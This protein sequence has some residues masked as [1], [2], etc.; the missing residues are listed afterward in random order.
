MELRKIP[1]GVKFPINEGV[2]YI[3]DAIDAV[4]KSKVDAAIALARSLSAEQIALLADAMAK[5]TQEQLDTAVIKGDSSVEAAQ[6]RFP[7]EGDSYPTLK[8]RLD[9]EYSEVTTQLNRVKNDLKLSYLYEKL[10]GTLIPY[11]PPSEF[12]LDIPFNIYISVSGKVFI[13]DYDVA[14]N[15]NKV[16]KIYYVDVKSGDNTNP[17]T[18]AQPFKDIGRALRYGDADEIIVKEGIYGWTSGYNGYTQ[19]KSYNL[20]GQGDVYVG[21]HRDNLIWTPH[22]TY[23]GV[24]QTNATSVFE[25][26]D[27]KNYELPEFLTL[28]NDIHGVS[29]TPNSYYIDSSN[30][31]Y[32]RTIDSRKPDDFILCNLVNNAAN[33]TN[34]DNVYFENIKFTNTVDITTTSN[35]NAMFHAKGCDFFYGSN[36]NG[37]YLKGVDFIVQNCRAK[38][39][40]RDGFNYHVSNGILSNGIE[41]DCE[42]KYNGRDGGNSNNGSTMHDGGHI[43]RIRGEYDHNHGPNVIDVNVGTKSLN[44]GVHAHSSTATSPISNADFRTRD[45]DMWLVNCVSHDSDYS[46]S[47]EGNANMYKD[48]S[49]LI[50]EEIVI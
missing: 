43:L 46:T 31:I 6:A 24:Y 2:K 13:G 32:V 29:E 10:Y 17:G 38:F 36:S 5:S 3:N 40:T 50:G 45:A 23:A 47:V 48:N 18:E 4:E 35:N 26:I 7:V 19:T 34:V 49:L 44:I 14:V 11:T 27:I 37:L 12:P 33:A 20:I 15:K 28:Q 1:V 30:N 21:A 8:K 39:A 41:I 25:V 9:T 42:G 16:T 22:A